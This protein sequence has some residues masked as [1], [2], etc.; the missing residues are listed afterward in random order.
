MQA[1]LRLSVCLCSFAVCG[2][3][4]MDLLEG[5]KGKEGKEDDDTLRCSLTIIFLSTWT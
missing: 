4:P 1:Y 3:G 5:S 2:L